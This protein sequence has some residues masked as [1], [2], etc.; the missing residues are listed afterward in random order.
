MKDMFE[1]VELRNKQTLNE[2]V[3]QRPSVGTTAPPIPGSTTAAQA[4]IS[5]AGTKLRSYDTGSSISDIVAQAQARRAERNAAFEANK[6]RPAGSVQPT[7][8]PNATAPAQ[9]G[10][11]K[12]Q[13]I[14]NNANST[15]AGIK[16]NRRDVQRQYGTGGRQ[17]VNAAPNTQ[18]KAPAPNV[19]AKK[20]ATPSYGDEFSAPARPNTQAQAPTPNVAAKKPAPAT[21][22]TR[23]SAPSYG[24]EFDA[25]GYQTSQ[26]KINTFQQE[27]SKITGIQPGQF[28]RLQSYYEPEIS[29]DLIQQTV[30]DR[31]TNTVNVGAEVANRRQQQATNAVASAP[32]SAPTQAQ[33]SSAVTGSA[34]DI[35]TNTNVSRNGNQSASVDLSGSQTVQTGYA[36]QQ[37]AQAEI[38]SLRR[39]AEMVQQAAVSTRPLTTRPN[40]AIVRSGDVE[41]VARDSFTYGTDTAIANQQSRSQARVVGNVQG[42]AL[43]ARENIRQA[44]IRQSQTAER[45]SQLGIAGPG[46]EGYISSR[47]YDAYKKL[48]AG[49]FD[50]ATGLPQENQPF[51][52]YNVN[53]NRQAMGL[54]PLGLSVD[55]DQAEKLFEPGQQYMGREELKR[56]MAPFADQPM[57]ARMNPTS[58]QSIEGLGSQRENVYGAADQVFRPGHTPTP[59]TIGQ[60]AANPQAFADARYAAQMAFNDS[61]Q[62]GIHV[63]I[64]GDIT[65]PGFAASMAGVPGVARVSGATVATALTGGLNQ[66]PKATGAISKRLAGRLGAG[67]ERAENIGKTV[68]ALTPG[69]RVATAGSAGATITAGGYSGLGAAQN[70][71][72]DYTG[73]ELSK[74]DIL[75]AAGETLPGVSSIVGQDSIP[76]TPSELAGAVRT[77]EFRD[78][79]VTPAAAQAADVP[80]RV[81]GPVVN[82]LNRI[83]G[84][85]IEFDSKAYADQIAKQGEELARMIGYDRP[86]GAQDAAEAGLLGT[87]FGSNVLSNLSQEQ[88]EQ[89]PQQSPIRQLFYNPEGGLIHHDEVQRRLEGFVAASREGLDQAAA[90]QSAI[91]NS[92][93]S[94]Q[95]YVDSFNNVTDAVEKPS[96]TPTTDDA[97][98]IT[99]ATADR[100]TLDLETLNK[101]R[102]NVQRRVQSDTGEGGLVD[103]FMEPIEA[104]TDAA[105]LTDSEVDALKYNLSSERIAS[106]IRNKV[107]SPSGP[108]GLAR[109]GGLASGGEENPFFKALR[110]FQKGMMFK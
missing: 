63:P 109:G 106:E 97:G 87:T 11:S 84:V 6:T 58:M 57:S 93:E 90:I 32:S 34:A 59:M 30:Q 25:P 16:S 89:I 66:A 8:S 94:A 43:N 80:G 23:S 104:I 61:S 75:T 70:Y 56:F 45:R 98:N 55:M 95:S 18:A 52:Q 48:M 42:Q 38:D 65:S 92:V 51:G 31:A 88:I 3:P 46:E 99:G 69:A 20:S 54:E 82:M 49:G 86:T 72:K 13:T 12:A 77:K 39:D 79:V 76:A 73:L 85:N 108:M 71:A 96:V 44:L 36:A 10:V 78:T 33:A 26:S 35:R 74:L 2:E 28:S 24:N 62:M 15:L 19:A 107:A 17:N 101:E 41:S 91:N 40:A 21:N 110:N 29:D 9:S 105:S 37:T 5:G 53:A 50:R 1:F 68:A 7:S 64:V 81:G 22:A 102:D 83:P 67:A 14:I 4:A 47:Q 60:A 100:G 103:Q 27:V